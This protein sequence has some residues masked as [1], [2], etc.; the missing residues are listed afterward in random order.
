MFT[1]FFAIIKCK[2]FVLAIFV[3]GVLAFGVS[4]VKAGK[5]QGV[6][7]WP[8]FRSMDIK[9]GT[10]KRIVVHIEN[11]NNDDIE[12]RKVYRNLRFDKN[13]E[14]IVSKDSLGA[15]ASWLRSEMRNSII[16]EKG[17]KRVLESILEVPKA[18]KAKGYYPVILFRFFS[19]SKEGK[20]TFLG[21]V[22]SILYLDVTEITGK[23]AKK[24][25][26]L[27]SFEVEKDFLFDP[28]T[29]FKYE[30]ENAGNVH[31]L[32]RGYLE[33]YDPSGIRQINNELLNEKGI[34]LLPG[35][36]LSEK[37]FWE[38]VTVSSF[39]PPIGNYKAVLN[40]QHEDSGTQMAKSEITFFVFPAQYFVY[41]ALVLIFL[42][43]VGWKVRKRMRATK[44][45]KL[46]I[47]D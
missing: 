34:F 13:K 15:P 10:K 8:T 7:V 12:I 21:E 5:P 14:I 39:F 35:K 26:F 29:L 27:K 33:V 43:L 44:N 36:A 4:D 20:V 47:K 32:P 22:G 42:L 3:M 46:R 16:L 31:V 24:K 41:L 25:L 19:R 11:L 28:S 40:F 2:L 18:T 23:K 17:R 9:A 6:R 45:D 38:D 37:W 30:I 1:S